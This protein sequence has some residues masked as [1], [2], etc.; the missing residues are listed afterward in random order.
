[1]QAATNRQNLKREKKRNRQDRLQKVILV[2]LICQAVLGVIVALY[3][4]YLQPDKIISAF[5]TMENID[6]VLMIDTS[7]H[8]EE[9]REQQQDVVLRFSEDMLHAMKKQRDQTL[10]ANI[11]RVEAMKRNQSTAFSRFLS[12]FIRAKEQEAGN[13]RDGTDLPAVTALWS[14][15]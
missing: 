11:E 13:G 5:V 12:H 7:N 9:R 1:M 2:F 6:M 10:Q 8:M 3:K 14:D 15:I 4:T